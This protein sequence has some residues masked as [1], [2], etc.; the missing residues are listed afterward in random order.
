MKRGKNKFPKPYKSF[1]EYELATGPLKNLQY[2]GTKIEYI[3]E[4]KEY[5]PD[6]VSSDGGFWYEVK[7]R[8]RTYDELKKYISVRRAL[9]EATD[10]MGETKLRF[11]L[12]NPDVKA[13]PQSK[14]ITLGQWL[15]KHGFE[16]CSI[17]EI[18]D[19]WKK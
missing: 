10:I 5:T 4:T 8:M 18:P 1:I 9:D 7:G 12:S 2:E 14:K 17:E 16:W 11:I 19:E 15:T 13:Y 3:P 6:F